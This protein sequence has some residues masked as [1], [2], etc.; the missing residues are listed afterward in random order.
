MEPT[1][2]VRHLLHAALAEHGQQGRR[3]LS[4]GGGAACPGVR[5][6]LTHAAGTCRSWACPERCLCR[7]LLFCSLHMLI[8]LLCH[9]CIQATSWG[10]SQKTSVQRLRSN[11]GPVRTAWPAQ[12][13]VTRLC[14]CS[15]VESGQMH[16]LMDGS[17]GVVEFPEEADHYCSPDT[18]Q[19]LHEQLQ[20]ASAISKKL[21][22]LDFEVLGLLLDDQL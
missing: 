14:M 13:E 15:M 11:Q 17:K 4:A 19:R 21:A 9:A 16:A 18:A 6:L 20:Q 1:A 7:A 10:H 12:Q 8:R 3:A 2:F 22:K 5:C